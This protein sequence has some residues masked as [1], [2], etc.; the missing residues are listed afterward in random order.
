MRLYHY[1]V[2]AILVLCFSS[3]AY[4]T[5]YP[6]KIEVFYEQSG[7]VKRSIENV[8]VSYRRMDD[9]KEIKK[10]ISIQ[11]PGN[12]EEASKFM[13]QY[14]NSKEGQEKIQQIVSGY[15]I[16]GRA[17]SLGVKELPAVVIDEHLVVY[18]T[19]DVLIAL[20]EWREYKVREDKE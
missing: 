4:S 19:T 7:V 10:S 3:G 6:N 9:A 13:S 5:E 17:F 18:G 16:V 8:A 1:V 15:Q 20:D 12:L 11:L 14:A 2:L